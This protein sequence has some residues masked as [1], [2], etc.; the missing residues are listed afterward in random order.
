MLLSSIQNS[1][2]HYKFTILY[3]IK[4]AIVEDGCGGRG[5]GRGRGK[6]VRNYGEDHVSIVSV[7][8]SEPY[9]QIVAFMNVTAG[10][11]HPS[12]LDIPDICKQA[13]PVGK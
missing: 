7:Y 5:R 11:K 1:G 12:A 13:G 4:R 8:I 9:M 10:I 6:R 2:K 3:I